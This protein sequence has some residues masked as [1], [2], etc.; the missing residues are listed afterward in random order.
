MRCSDGDRSMV[1]YVN[2]LA[3]YQGKGGQYGGGWYGWQH[4]NFE[5]QQWCA[6]N[7]A[8]AGGEWVSDPQFPKREPGE[9]EIADMPSPARGDLASPGEGSPGSRPSQ[10][11]APPRSPYEW[12]KKPN[13]QTQP[14]PGTYHFY[15]VATSLQLLQK[16]KILSILILANLGRYYLYDGRPK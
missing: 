6:W 8:P 3:M 11:P 15:A 2:P 7:G 16:L 1:N 10:P 12:M 13:Y 5:E 4:Q 14:N 9:R